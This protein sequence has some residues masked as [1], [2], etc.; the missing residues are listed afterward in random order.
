MF[1]LFPAIALWCDA[2]RNGL[3]GGSCKRLPVPRLK[4]EGRARA[5]LGPPKH[6]NMTG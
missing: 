5:R 2:V 6:W 4:G 3:A 1:R